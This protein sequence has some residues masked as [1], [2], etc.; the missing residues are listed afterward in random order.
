MVLVTKYR[1]PVLTGGVKEIVYGT[2][3]DIFREKGLVIMEMNGVLVGQLFRHDGQREFSR[4]GSGLHPEPVS[5]LWHSPKAI[6]QQLLLTCGAWLL[7]MWY[8]AT[9]LYR[10]LFQIFALSSLP[11]LSLCEIDDNIHSTVN[12]EYTCV[13]HK[14]MSVA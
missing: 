10:S 4:S 7:W 3:R 13:D 11:E 12:S 1:H 8:S 14:I 5:L 9:T 6:A 2:I